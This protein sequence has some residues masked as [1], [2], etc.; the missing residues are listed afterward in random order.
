M[1]KLLPILYKIGDYDIIT[2]IEVALEKPVSGQVAQQ[3]TFSCKNLDNE[4]VYED[5]EWRV[6]AAF[7]SVYCGIKSRGAL[8]RT[9]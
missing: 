4:G 3:G 7:P 5:L 2:L 1:R 8:G 6:L 9:V